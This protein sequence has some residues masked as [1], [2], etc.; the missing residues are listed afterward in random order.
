MND[1]QTDITISK[2]SLTMKIGQ[3]EKIEL[4]TNERIVSASYASSDSNVAT[5]DQNGNIQAVGS[6]LAII[7]V[8]TDKGQ[9][10][11][12]KVYVPQNNEVEFTP[13][14]SA[15]FLLFFDMSVFV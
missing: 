7:E 10:Y 1:L 9:T 8:K 2:V 15:F 6:G 13:L 12:C 3:I 11:Y 14:N 4:K 5:V